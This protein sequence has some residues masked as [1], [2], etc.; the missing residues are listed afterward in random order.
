MGGNRFIT[1]GLPSRDPRPER[2]GHVSVRNFTTEAIEKVDG[3][4]TLMKGDAMTD[5]G[6]K[7]A[8]SLENALGM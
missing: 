8:W 4:G 3:R 6:R 2:I 7:G 1:G 5:S